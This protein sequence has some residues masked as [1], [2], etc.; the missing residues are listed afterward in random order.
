MTSLLVWIKWKDADT[1]PYRFG[2]VLKWKSGRGNI[3]LVDCFNKK[4]YD[5]AIQKGGTKYESED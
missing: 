4:M 3:A 2:T 5:R 1:D